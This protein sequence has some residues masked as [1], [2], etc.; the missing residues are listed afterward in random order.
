[1][2]K[3]DN[4]RAWAALRQA[5][6][7]SGQ[8][9]PQDRA[10]INAVSKRY[11]ADYAEDR[12]V[13][14]KAYAAAMRALAQEYPD[15]LD[16][17]TLLAEALMDTMPW[18]Y[19]LKDR[20]PKPETEEAL[21]AL[22]RVIA[23]DPDHPGATHFY[24]HALEAGPNPEAALPAADHLLNWA[25]QA[26][27]L[28]HMPSH[29]Y[30]R[31]G[32]YHDAALSNER[33]IKADQSYVEACRAQGFYPGLYVPHNMHFFWF[34]TIFEGRSADALA[35]AAKVADYARDNV[36]GPSQVLQAPEFRNLPWLT[37]ARFGRWDDVLKVPQPPSTNSYI[38]DRIVWHFT[39]GLAFA[40]RKET[41]AAG[42]EQA[43]MSKLIASDSVKA[44][45]IPQFPARAILAVPDHLLAGKIAASRGDWEESI[46]HLEQA[47]QAEDALPY[48]EP[49]Y[50]PIPT[51]PTLGAALLQA[52]HAAKAEIIFREDLKIHPR[53]GWGLFGLEQS[54]R[55]QGKADAAELVHQEFVRAWKHADVPLELAWF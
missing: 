18:D 49:A 11:Q 10:Y 48:M 16:A 19:W 17:Q 33:A 28:V 37:Q 15:D 5:L 6:D 43:E 14:D 36:C 3:E 41:D 27:H 42:Q 7:R 55:Q 40:A 4:D 53:N 24:I 50:W 9:S 34:A 30:M 47:T 35:A 21:A 23:R 52:G 46:R 8:A 51:R 2:T 25:P 13:L 31:V 1:M 26:G 45:E 54:L 29:I 12:S 32:Q 22:R 20:S 39:R 44:L 38:V